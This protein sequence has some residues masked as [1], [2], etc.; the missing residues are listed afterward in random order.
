[1]IG[2]LGIAV[3]AGVIAGVSPCVLPVLPVLFMTGATEG[4]S[5]RTRRPL[6][7][8]AGLIV[9]FTVITLVGAEVLTLLH[10]PDDL[11]PPSAS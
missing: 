7:V 4:E 9:S 8:V 6:A 3:V 2:L 10:L 5:K 1:V 11:L